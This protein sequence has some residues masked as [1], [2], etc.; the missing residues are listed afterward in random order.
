M[1]ALQLH[2]DF[3]L[4][5]SRTRL[6]S[7][8]HFDSRLPTM[9]LSVIILATICMLATLS[10]ALLVPSN[11][12]QVEMETQEL[13][14][15]L[16]EDLHEQSGDFHQRFK[17]LS[18]QQGDSQEGAQNDDNDSRIEGHKKK[19]KKPNDGHGGERLVPVVL[20]VMSK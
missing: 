11:M 20:G 8:M 16:I 2:P 7:N 9:S 12:A 10:Q 3:H 18:F 17:A 1:R 14:R 4:Y 15:K 13:Y 5:Q 19:T 6:L